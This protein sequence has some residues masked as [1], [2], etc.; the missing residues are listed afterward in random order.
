MKKLVSLA[1]LAV[2]LVS[3]FMTGCVPETIRTT[4]RNCITIPLR[5]ELCSKKALDVASDVMISYGFNFVIYDEQ[6]GYIRTE[7]KYNKE[8]GLLYTTRISIKMN[9]EDK[10]IRICPECDG[11]PDRCIDIP[12]IKDLLQDMRDRLK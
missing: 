8:N 9:F 6:S 5:D 4:E 1:V 10:Y 3:L 11:T 7:W 2:S 12:H